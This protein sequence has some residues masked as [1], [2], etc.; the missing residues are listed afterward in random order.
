MALVTRKYCN[1]CEAYRTY[2][3]R[4]C[5]DCY[6]RERRERMAAWKAQTV[7]EKLLDVHKRLLKLEQS[8]P[9]Y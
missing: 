6:E 2:V 8:P 1:I 5:S 9:R 4:K 7:D 3:N